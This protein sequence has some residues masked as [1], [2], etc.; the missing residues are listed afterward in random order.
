MTKRTQYPLMLNPHSDRFHV[1][2]EKD[3]KLLISRGMRCKPYVSP[4]G[5]TGWEMFLPYPD[6]STELLER[7][8]ASKR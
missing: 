2:E 8:K 4:D 3:M 1:Y 7:Q 5:R 6:G